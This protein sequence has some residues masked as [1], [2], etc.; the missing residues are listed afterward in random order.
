MK[1]NGITIQSVERAISILECFTGNRVELSLTEIA[2]QTGLNRSTTYGIVNTLALGGFL[3]QDPGS[4]LYRLGIRLFEYG[5]LVG[6]R[7]DLRAEALP[8]CRQLAS[9]YRQVAHLAIRS[10]DEI[11]YIDK[12]NEPSMSIAYS[13]VGKRAPMYCTAVGKA[14]LAFMDDA[15]ID[16]YLQR[17][18]LLPLTE[19]TIIQPDELKDELRLIRTRTYA[20]DNEEVEI[21]LTCVGAPV[22]DH[23]GRV[24]AAISTSGVTSVMTK[25]R[26]ASITNDILSYSKTISSRLGYQP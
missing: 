5:N 21:G 6:S 7:I 15:F 20:L 3:E 2:E 13:Y 1:K 8:Y 19:N 4:R 14:M 12:V 16:D 25:E 24:A 23:K 18:A 10:G 26:I 22:F 9:D 17:T 11:V